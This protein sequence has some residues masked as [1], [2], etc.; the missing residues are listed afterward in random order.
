[1]HRHVMS[2]AYLSTYAKCSRESVVDMLVERTEHSEIEDKKR[3][4]KEK[5]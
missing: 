5:Q 4:S 3:Q 2:E 1:M